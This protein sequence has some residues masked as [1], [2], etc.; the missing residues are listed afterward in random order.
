MTG[1]SVKKTLRYML[2]TLI[3]T[4]T[5]L[6]SSC[7]SANINGTIILLVDISSS[8]SM[9][10]LHLQLDSYADSM[11]SVGGL[12]GAHVVAIVFDAVPRLISSG[13]NLDAYHAFTNYPRLEAQYRGNTCLASALEFVELM[14]PT[15]PQPV[16]LDISGD[17]EANCGRQATIPATLDRIAAQNVQVNTLF[18]TSGD[19]NAMSVGPHFTPYFFYQ[20]MRRN[21]GFSVVANGFQEFEI[22]LFEKLTLE[23]SYL[24]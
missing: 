20:S 9:S 17:G 18:I 14:I 5:L 22:S 10:N 23:L 3:L 13:T 24:D 6:W 8:I 11:T 1:Y 19:F 21:N 12:Y 7:A 2:A 16:I 15:L 4:I